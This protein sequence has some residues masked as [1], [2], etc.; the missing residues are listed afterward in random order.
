MVNLWI[1]DERKE[2]EGWIVAKT[3]DEAIEL[4]NKFEF[5]CISFDHDLGEGGT[6][7]TVITYIESLAFNNCNFRCPKFK[8][9]S[10]NP[11]GR[12]RIQQV[13]DSIDRILK[14]RKTNGY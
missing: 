12:G 6:G 9:H 3:A 4:I 8:I 14:E 2:P 10:A 11:V 13:I 7:Y 5:D 1:D